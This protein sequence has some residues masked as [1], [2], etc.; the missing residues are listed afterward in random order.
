MKGRLRA[1]LRAPHGHCF[2]L[3]NKRFLAGALPRRTSNM[4]RCIFYQKLLCSMSAVVGV[5]DASSTFVLPSNELTAD[6]HPTLTFVFSNEAM[7]MKSTTRIDRRI[8]DGRRVQYGVSFSSQRRVRLRHP[9]KDLKREL[10]MRR[11]Q[12]AFDKIQSNRG[13]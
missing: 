13:M 8:V 6:G 9:K 4:L 2:V 12:R 5:Q 11:K 1:L 10:I 3:P 7:P